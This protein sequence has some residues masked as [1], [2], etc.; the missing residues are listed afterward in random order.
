MQ[1]GQTQR[2]LGSD[3]QVF[4][5]NGVLSTHHHGQV[6][7]TQKML[8]VARDDS[9]DGDKNLQKFDQSLQG[10]SVSTLSAEIRHF[11][12]RLTMPG[13]YPQPLI[14]ATF[15]PSCQR[16]LDA[17]SNSTNLVMS[18]DPDKLKLVTHDWYATIASSTHCPCIAYM[19]IGPSGSMS[20]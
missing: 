14:S 1:G 3:T 2:L 20:V 7:M 6:R 18:Y 5:G 9:S 17:I 12:L 10:T 15:L 19:S 8:R 16:L 11:L 13:T 4:P